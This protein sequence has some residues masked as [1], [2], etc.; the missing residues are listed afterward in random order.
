MSSEI[1]IRK[2]GTVIFGLDEYKCI[3][4]V[5]KDKKPVYVNPGKYKVD[6]YTIWN[7]S[8]KPHNI[9]FHHGNDIFSVIV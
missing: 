6:S 9:F 1:E 7:Y 8:S 2:H 4:M 3:S 5:D